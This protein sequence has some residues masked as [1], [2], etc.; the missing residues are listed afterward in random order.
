MTDEDKAEL[1]AAATRYETL[2]REHDKVGMEVP[3]ED[4][5]EKTKAM[6]DFHLL[7][8]E[9]IAAEATL[10]ALKTKPRKALA[11]Q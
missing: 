9:V 2:R 11:A 4:P 7:E 3:P 5:D 6:V 8:A 10:T 1:I